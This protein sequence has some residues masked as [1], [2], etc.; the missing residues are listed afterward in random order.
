MSVII[1]WNMNSRNKPGMPEMGITLLEA[2]IA[3]TIFSFFTGAI[4]RAVRASSSSAQR[5]S[6]RLYLQMEAR[7]ALL[8]LYSIIQ[9]GIE[10]IVP[11]PGATLSHVS[12]RDLH[13]NIHFIYPRK[14]EEISAAEKEDRY[15]IVLVIQS[16]GNTEPSQEKVILKHVKKITFAA[17]DYCGVHVNLTLS[18][19]GGN[20]SVVN[21]IH[22][23][24]S[25]ALDIEIASP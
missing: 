13:N 3:M 25:S 15:D 18:N 21:F 2:V 6:Q 24:N 20:F 23:K 22:L 8:N 17:H 11:Q 4:Y 16:P 7:R 19:A 9:S 1:K 10:L 5:I 14:N 12:L